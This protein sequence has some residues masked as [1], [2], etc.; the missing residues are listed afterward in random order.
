MRLR[1]EGSETG[2]ESSLKIAKCRT[3]PC[4]FPVPGPGLEGGRGKTGYESV[5][6]GELLVSEG[7]LGW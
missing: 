3:V 1:A 5:E 4:Q 2:D 7:D 6:C